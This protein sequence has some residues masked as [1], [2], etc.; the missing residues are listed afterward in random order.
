MDPLT[1]P[2]SFSFPHFLAPVRSFPFARVLRRRA[3]V[4]AAVA[5][6]CLAA[7]H[8]RPRVRPTALLLAAVDFPPFRARLRRTSHT[9]PPESAPPPPDRPRRTSG[10]LHRHLR[11]PP[12]RLDSLSQPL[13]PS[14][15]V[16]VSPP[17]PIQSPPPPELGVAAIV[18]SFSTFSDHC[19]HQFQLLSRVR[20]F[21]PNSA[22]WPPPVPDSG[23]L[24]AA[25]VGLLVSW[26]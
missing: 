10:R 22:S 6:G 8:C 24:A 21:R 23:E 7:D 25:A 11:R 12:L 20:R 5:A 19:S 18:D 4:C 13:S 26:R 2:P 17:P 1:P 15:L 9:P 14:S 16:R 3:R